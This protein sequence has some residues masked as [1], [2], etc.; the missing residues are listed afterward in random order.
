VLTVG[1]DRQGEGIGLALLVSAL[2]TLRDRGAQVALMRIDPA[3]EWV[4]RMTRLLVFERT[5]DDACYGFGNAVQRTAWAL[6]Q[7]TTTTFEGDQHE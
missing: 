6:P 3:R 4:V 5:N 1:Q 7:G 2:D